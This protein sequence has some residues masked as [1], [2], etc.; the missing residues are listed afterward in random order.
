MKQKKIFLGGAGD[1]NCLTTLKEHQFFSPSTT[2]KINSIS[3]FNVQIFSK[4]L[5]NP[6][7]IP[8]LILSFIPLNM[9]SVILFFAACKL[10]QIECSN[11]VFLILLHLLT[12]YKLY[13]E[14]V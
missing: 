10:L 7:V 5:N 9:S 2:P 1:K 3:E 4:T 6:K 8:G 12:F 14:E 11:N 13:V